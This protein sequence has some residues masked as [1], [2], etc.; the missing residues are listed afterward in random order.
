MWV[1]Q[2]QQRAESHFSRE[3]SNTIFR[4]GREEDKTG[5]L[6]VHLIQVQDPACK[7]SASKKPPLSRSWLGV[8]HIPST[9]ATQLQA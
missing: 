3:K 1:I 5:H 8:F 6:G 9:I 7:T 2:G 4:W